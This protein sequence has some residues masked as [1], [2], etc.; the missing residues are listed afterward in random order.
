MKNIIM[1]LSVLLKCQGRK[2]I[3]FQSATV[4]GGYRV[5]TGPALPDYG[6]HIPVHH[7]ESIWKTLV[8]CLP[9]FTGSETL[10]YFPRVGGERQGLLRL[11]SHKELLF[12][13]YESCSFNQEKNLHI[14]IILDLTVSVKSFPEI[15]ALTLSLSQES[16]LSGNST[17][18]LLFT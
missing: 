17:H 9:S 12:A 11:A 18:A 2:C 8:Y 7:S 1:L 10:L 5:H 14:L 16:T 6:I 15:S 13:I 4:S 3:F